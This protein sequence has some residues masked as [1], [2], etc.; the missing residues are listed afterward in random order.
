LALAI[1]LAIICGIAVAALSVGA[2]PAQAAEGLVKIV[3]LGDSLTAGYGLPA[4]ATFPVKL[5][6][7]LKAAGHAVEISNAGVSGDT[8]SGGLARLD[9][10][11]PEGT[12]AVIL[13]LGANDALRGVDPAVTRKALETIITRLKARGIAVLLAGMMAPRNLGPEFA[14][15]FDAIY[16]ELAAKYGL[17]FDAFFLEGVAAERDLNQADGMHPTAAGVDVI[18]ARMVP[19]VA[20]LIARLRGNGAN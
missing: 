3:A 19:K 4:D 20:D 17:V 18:V 15:D 16:P 2:R 12:D 6:A 8:A 14:R 10:S 13:Q 5:A 7:A 9:W 1:L 11:V